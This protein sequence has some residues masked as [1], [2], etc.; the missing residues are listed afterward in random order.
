MVLPLICGLPASTRAPLGPVT[1]TELKAASRFC[2]NVSE[3]SRGALATVLP[4]SGLA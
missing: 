2:V 1:W 4:T 3:T